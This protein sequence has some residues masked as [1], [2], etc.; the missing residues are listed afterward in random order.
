MSKHGMKHT[1]IYEIWCGMKKRCYNQN[2]KNFPQ[3]GGKGIIVCDDWKN[4]FLK[5]YDWSMK[6]GYQEN[7]TIDRI[8]N[9]G[10]YEPSNCRWIT[11]KQQQRNRTNNI[12]LEHN[13]ETKTLSGWCIIM[14]EPYKRIYSRIKSALYHYG[15]Y[16][17]NDLFYLK[18]I[19]KIYTEKYYKRKHYTRKINQ[20]SKNGDLIKKWDSVK[21]V[22]KSGFNR[23]AV[24]SCCRGRSKTSGGYI[25]KYAED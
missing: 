2:S 17:F 23:N 22:E 13:G 14:N 12:Y 20:Y 8:D 25:W 11:H 16:D 10:N 7:L 3:Y 5:F 24:T 4:D 9:N 18:P 1:R 6:N 19:K 21:E 15:K